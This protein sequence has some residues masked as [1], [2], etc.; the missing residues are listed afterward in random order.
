MGLGG[1]EGQ[2][3]VSIVQGKIISV[4]HIKYILITRN[5][6]G[7]DIHTMYIDIIYV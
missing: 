4:L 1:W 6:I 7:L 5:V 2:R 3:S